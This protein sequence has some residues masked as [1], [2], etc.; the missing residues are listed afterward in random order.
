[1]AQYILA[2]DQGTSSTKTLLFDESGKPVAKASVP[3]ASQYEGV[4]AEQAPE[5]IYQNV[6]ESVSACIGEF[7]RSGASVRDIAVCGISNQR[8]TFI[9]WDKNGTPLYNAILWQCKRSVEICERLTRQG[10]AETIRQKT[11]L[12]IDPYFSGTKLIWLYQNIEKVRRAIDTGNAFFG[13]V[14][15]WLLYKLTDGRS[16][17]T[18]YTNASR[19]MFFNLNTLS[20][21][22]E[23][24]RVFGLSTLNLP[25]IKPSA[26]DFGETDFGGLLEKPVRIGAMIGDSHAAA[27]GEGCYQPGTAKAT[28]GTGC[29]ILMNVGDTVKPSANGM[30]S[31]I[32][33]SMDNT[34]KY[35]L[36]G[37]IVTCGAAIEWVKQ[38]L[39]LFTES[40]QTEGMA[41]SVPDNGGVYLV[42][43]FSGLGAPHW[44][45]E[46]K[47][48]LTGLT[49]GSNKNHIV[50]AALESIP[51]Q[52]KDVIAAMEADTEITLQHLMTDGGISGNRFIM[53]FLADLLGKEV[54]NIGI[55]D[56]SA[57]GAALLA[58]LQQGIFTDVESLGRLQRDSSVYAPVAN[59]RM[60]SDY[61]GWKRAIE[62]AK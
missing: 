36:E 28:L 29:S 19:T 43:A 33:W 17:Y 5:G 7:R 1:M 6:L 11:G 21:D 39:G 53:Q 61:E 12:I 27:F 57:L 56:V 34:V 16:Y 44:D 3:L 32:C 9:V 20:W 40:R 31:T 8:E 46:R 42:P 22:A 38:E 24:L 37:V 58:G 2:M 15:T 18:D 54:R 23:L 51:Y 35:A 30:V 55:A 41:F 13:T 26:A 10:A 47:A 52:I 25:A 4:F 62:N 49:F 60:T 59:D 45:M 48:S 14:D 50:R